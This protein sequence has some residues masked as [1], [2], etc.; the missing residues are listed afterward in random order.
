[1]YEWSTILHICA[2]QE[3]PLDYYAR[4]G[5]DMQSLVSTANQ[6]VEESLSRNEIVKYNFPYNLRVPEKP[7]D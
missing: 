5:L 2:S 3:G 7:E 4:I 6:T 1:M